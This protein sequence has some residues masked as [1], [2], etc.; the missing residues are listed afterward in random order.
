MLVSGTSAVT[1]T[2]VV[3]A[4]T[5]RSLS[6]TLGALVPGSSAMTGA[7]VTGATTGEEVAH[8]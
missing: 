8:T 3:G 6:G 1:G 5:T 2:S 7:E 4:S